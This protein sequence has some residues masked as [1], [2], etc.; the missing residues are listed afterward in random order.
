MEPLQETSFEKAF[1]WA[2]IDNFNEEMN[3]LPAERELAAQYTFSAEFEKRMQKLLRGNARRE[4]LHAFAKFARRTAAAAA[5]ALIVF[6]SAVIVSPKV[7]S[8]V[9]E[10]YVEFF[11]EYATFTSPQNNTAAPSKLEPSY[12][13]EGFVE[14]ERVENFSKIKIRYE[15]QSGEL[16]W[17]YSRAAGTGLAVNN[18]NVEYEQI[19]R[20]DTMYHS[21][22]S[23]R[24]E[25]TY[26]RV[27]W[28]KNGYQYEVSGMVIIEELQNMAFSLK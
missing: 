11:K 7:R 19:V 1:E 16:A 22:K 23:T 27:V 13:P 28:E 12:I 8:F 24:F 18:D 21:F 25:D 9:R 5:I 6:T 20:E 10:I 14:T 15:N 2:I 26:S 3:T 4:V 17:F